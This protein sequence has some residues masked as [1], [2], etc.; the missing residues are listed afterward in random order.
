MMNI[1]RKLNDK[2]R[3]IIMHVLCCFKNGKLPIRLFLSGSAGVGKST[4]INAIYQVLLN[5]FDDMPGEN[6]NK[7]KILLCA[8]SGKAAFLIG[9]TTLHTAFALPVT[10]YGGQ[11][12]DLSED[13]ANT[14][15]ENLFGLKLL[16]IDEISM[17]GSTMFSRIDTRLRQI[18]GRDRSFGGVSVLMV[19]D[20]Y[21]LPP[22]MDT[23]IYLPPKSCMLSVFSE[24]VLWSEFEL[25][26]LTEI[27]RQKEDKNFI[28]A[29]NN[30][31]RG[32]M[33]EN[34]IDL[35][36]SRET[37]EDD[38]PIDAV[39]LYADNR[40]VDIYNKLKIDLK[41]G[42]AYEF[43]AID[44]ILGKVN[45]KTRNKLLT[46]LKNKKRTECSGLDFKITLKIGIN[47][48]ITNN[49]D[50][51]DGLVNGACGIL[52]YITFKP[53]TVEPVKIWLDF[54]NDK[55]GVEQRRPYVKYM[56]EN[57][58]EMCLVPLSRIS[59]ILN[60]NDRMGYQIIREQFPITPAE[61]LTIHKSQGQTYEKV[62]IDLRNNYRMTRSML[63]VA[64]SRVTKIS[65]LYILGRFIPPKKPFPENSL[66]LEIKRLKQEKILE[67]A[68]SK[69][70]KGNIIKIIYQNVR[71]LNKNITN[72]NCDKW[73]KQADLLI[74]SETQTIAKDNFTLEG[75]NIIFRSDNY[76]KRSTRGIIC[77]I[78]KE[79][80]GNI[81][82]HIQK[83]ETINGQHRHIDLI[84]L[85]VNKVQVITGY[86][87]PSVTNTAFTYELSNILRK[88]LGNEKI[89]IGDFNYDSYN[90][91]G[92]L[93]K[94]LEKLNF[95]RALSTHV[96]TTNF[97]TQSD[98]IFISDRIFNYTA[99]VYE[100]FFS[101]HKPIFI[102]LNEQSEI[103][104]AS[105][106]T[107]F[108]ENFLSNKGNKYNSEKLSINI[109]SSHTSE[110]NKNVPI[111]CIILNDKIENNDFN[112]DNLIYPLP[113]TIEENVL[114]ENSWLDNRPLNEI[115]MIIERY[116][117]FSRVDVL[118]IMNLH[119][120][121]PIFISDVQIVGGEH[122]G[123]HWHCI[124]YDG[125]MLHIY[126]SLYFDTHS[127]YDLTLFEQKYIEKRYPNL[128]QNN[129]IFEKVTKQPD[130]ASCGIF[131]AAFAV[132]I[133]L[134]ENPSNKKYSTD[135]PKM[136][137]HC[138]RII[139]EKILL[140][141]PEE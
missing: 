13:V 4:V 86:K 87:S 113:Q 79:L 71:S 118:F 22:V 19:G 107:L 24:N 46:S 25:F 121:E 8:P 106:K 74:F 131:A 70:I 102:G 108:E 120:I 98:V 84:L 135:M 96:S 38:I 7:V 133:A 129:I 6:N 16:I 28:E 85:T 43:K 117:T 100:T 101:D 33:S 127:Y 36:R 123:N 103:P 66:E 69:V 128:E 48:M 35:I 124:Y 50:V 61:A 82:G 47:Y 26:E 54:Q 141:F 30:L 45:S 95:K 65:N 122:C 21:Q 92:F 139:K 67:L 90:D 37:T 57:C 111:K 109:K 11:M 55:V 10:Q 134:G 80:N 39:R 49:V 51:A 105:V 40:S 17:V 41:D 140:P 15:R 76:D 119:W 136:R 110:K 68:Y 132:S 32:T 81:N 73:Y 52:K 72:I 114:K 64:L 58:M 5:Y 23:S 56:S 2:Q 115:M 53:G 44:S 12:P 130:L 63:Y 138:L 1:L 97:N 3:E 27:M 94:H 99:G 125:L 42:I 9:G 29:L 20:L 126:D 18:M 89:V 75:F 91:G 14:I 31:A 104:I 137:R 112:I 60:V 77:F 88:S 78:R 34:N 62:C 83:D 93:E 116:T 59:V